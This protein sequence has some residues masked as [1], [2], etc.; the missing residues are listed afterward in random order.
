MS[1][2]TLQIWIDADACPRDVKDL[3]YRAS[4]RLQVPVRVVANKLMHTPPSPHIH[5]VQVPGGP[6]VADD[7]IVAHAAAHDLAVTADVPLAARLVAKTVVVINPRGEEYDAENI[8]E[9]LSMRDFLTEA[10]DNGVVTGGPSA[11]GPK[12]RQRF[13]NSLDRALQRLS[14]R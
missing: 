14:R 4:T 1:D 11:F 2:L 8:G 10:R 12:D 6:D 3:V 5:M 7:Y 13:A 9:R